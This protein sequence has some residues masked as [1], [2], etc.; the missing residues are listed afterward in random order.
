MPKPIKKLIIN[1]PF[2]E[3]YQHW[4][5]NKTIKEFELKQ[6]RRP[7]SYIISGGKAKSYDEFGLIKEIPLVNDIRHRMREWKKSNYSGVTGVT[8]RLLEF[9]NENREIS[10]R[11]YDFFFCQLEAIETLIF[12]IEG[13]QDMK[14]GL[15]IPRDEA[16]NRLCCK[17][18]TG[19]GKTVVM[20][21][22]V[23]WQILNKVTYPKDARFS[24][25][26]FVV[27]PNLTV[28]DRLRVLKLSG[29]NSYYREY[30]IVPNEWRD[31]LRQGKVIIKNWH[32]LQWET[33]KQISQRK[34]ADRRGMKSDTAYTREILEDIAKSKNIIV[35]NDE[36]HHAWRKRAELKI[37][38]TDN[39]T[40]DE[41]EMAT[42]WI[43]GLDRLNRT[44]GIRQIFDFS[45]T[46]YAPTGK[47]ADERNLFEWIVS[48]FG[49][50][51]AI[52]AGIV[53]TP[54]FAIGD[55]AS[56]DTKRLK[57]KLYHIYENEK[58]Q[59]DLN[60][61]AER[62]ESLPDIVKLAYTHLSHS[63]SKK[64]EIWKEKEKNQKKFA[65]PVM[66]SIVNRKET[67][68]RVE[69][70]LKENDIPTAKLFKGTEKMLKVYSGMEDDENM[71][72]RLSAV[73]KIGSGGQFIHHVIAVQML[74]E[75]WNCRTVTHI[76]GLR[77][78]SSQLLCEQTIGR[79]L[80][81]MSY[82]LNENGMF[83]PEYV[84][85][86]GVPFAYLPQEG[87]DTGRPEEDPR[88]CIFPEP[89]RSQYEITWPNV[90]RVDYQLRPELKID[91]P[92][93][94]P[95]TADI[96]SIPRLA[97]LAPVIDGK[98]RYED[99]E[100]TSLQEFFEKEYEPDRMQ[101]LILRVTSQIYDK[102]NPEWKKGILKYHAVR[103]IFQLTEQFINS[104][105][106]Q[107]KPSYEKERKDLVVMMKMNE[108]VHKVFSLIQKDSV[109]ELS[110]IYDKD[111][112]FSSTKELGEWWT[113]KKT[114]IFKKTHINQCVTDSAWEYTHARELDKN[115][116]VQAWVKNDHLGFV[117]EY[118][119]EK[120]KARKYTPDFIIRLSNG[121]HLILE[122]KGIKK[123][124]D[125]QKW[126]FMKNWTKAISESLKKNWHFKISQDS[127]GGQI[128][129]IIE[130]ILGK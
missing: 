59:P 127:T 29:D 112:K 111:S 3:P 69:Q 120:G 56:T 97:E 63:W 4:K 40:K 73:G 94:S 79:G 44:V 52:E 85:V 115:K 37:K 10:G 74:S 88:S 104:P 91:F 90:E 100:L 96:S 6:G 64:Y 41:L 31:K 86:L 15:N 71:R 117:I 82:E 108:I 62:T 70:G 35:L 118:I 55:D 106:F 114:A 93:M 124:R 20:A 125:I 110:V 65:P 1:S 128:H 25:N 48:D 23:A 16:L 123:K 67:A 66:I 116:K 61:K 32:Q 119:D 129:R 77:A 33:E 75:G 26:I 28:R 58:V 76:M 103:M 8:R 46:P 22:S 49:L 13:R 92:G 95:Y 43:E 11:K 42:K 21:M 54:K 68:D 12:L 105:K 81:R 121:D 38:K 24:K 107:I 45:A 18:A 53:K 109:E 113:K 19:A 87:S 7:A 130:E 30:K 27:T 72:D 99:I 9:W 122:V 14:T 51:D 80:R 2:K 47:T 60:R 101:T 50:T 98:P 36:A 57:P 34:G 78:F 83:D 89:E 126:G 17:M 84:N 39:I 5:F 102:F